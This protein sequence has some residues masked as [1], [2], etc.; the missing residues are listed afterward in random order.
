M[1]YGEL[2]KQSFSIAR[3][4]RYL[5]FFGIFAGT[6]GSCN[7]PS[8]NFSSDG[9]SGDDFSSQASS[10]E[11]VALL[12]VL[13]IVVLLAVLVLVALSVLSQGALADSVAAID[14]G[15]RRSFGSAWRAGLATFWR[16][17]GEVLLIAVV[18]IGCLLAIGVPVGLLIYAALAGGDPS[19]GGI[20]LV[21]I[22]VLL[23]I[24]ALI[25]VFFPLGIISQLALRALIVGREGVVD[26]LR[27]GWRL[28]RA[29]IG[30][31]L[32]LGLIQ[33]GIGIAAALAVFLTALV[34]G[35]VLFIP[36]IALGLSGYYTAA[37]V[38]AVVAGLLLLVPFLAAIGALGTFNHAFWTLAYLRLTA[39]PAAGPMQPPP[40]GPMYPPP[41]GPM[42]VPPPGPMPPPAAA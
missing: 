31:S 24:V 14:R 30:T 25:A 8:G 26:A 5:W 13:G 7:A 21:V 11:F 36:A 15:E 39:P 35:L 32:L 19:A 28:F 6:S 9:G 4:H 27:T 3:H 38:A 16:V 2:I 12:I 10:S 17:L 23:A 29:R 37:I 41:P 34:V 18:A 42:G 20:A 1:N 22:V 40:P 33:A